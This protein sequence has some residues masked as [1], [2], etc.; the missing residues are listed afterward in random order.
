MS[1]F[2]I[3]LVTE[4]LKSHKSP[5]I[6]YI[7]AEVVKAGGETIRYEIHKYFYFEKGRNCL[8]SG[9]SRSYLSI[10]R[11]IKQNVVIIAAYHFYQLRT[12]FYSAFFCQG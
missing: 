12:K 8:R 7:P 6:N 11:A 2:D 3:G 4:K 9:R 5:G 10:R 1:V